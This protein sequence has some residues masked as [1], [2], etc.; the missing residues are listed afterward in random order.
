MRDV[1]LRADVSKANVFHHFGTKAGL[2]DAVLALAG[3]T[4]QQQHDVLRDRSLTLPESIEAF[5]SVNLQQM[6]DSPDM[7]SLFM[8]QLLN[9]SS[10]PEQADPQRAGA[11]NV[12][13]RGLND[14]VG[15][16]SERLNEV[17]GDAPIDGPPCHDAFGL[18]L[19]LLGGG[20]AYFQLRHVIERRSGVPLSQ[21]DVGDYSRSLLKLLRPGLETE[22]DTSAPA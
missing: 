16:L 11:E 12:I 18:A 10:R 14:L 6:L 5:A 22:R 17:R 3:R 7:I 20:F 4:F 15:I 19:I 13:G 9:A 2:Y 8:R 1:A 21:F